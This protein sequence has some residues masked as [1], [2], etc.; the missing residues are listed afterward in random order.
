M[1]SSDP[2]SNLLGT[3]YKGKV[4]DCYTIG[5][6]RVLIASDRLSA[7]DRV[8]PETIPYKGQVLNQLATFFLKQAE[9]IVQ[10]HLMAVPDPNV[11]IAKEVKAV[12]LEIV[13]RGYLTG[14]AWRDYQAGIFNNQYGLNL[15][16]GLTMN[17]RLENSIITPTT[18]VND[19]HDAPITLAQA[20]KIVSDLGGD[21]HKLTAIAHKLFAQGQSIAQ[22]A[23]LIL[24]D[25]KYEFGLN[26]YGE[27]ILIDEIHTPDS[28]RYWHEPYTPDNPQ[29]LSKEYFRE[30]L[31]D[32]GFKGD[33]ELPVLPADL[34]DELSNRYIDLYQQLT[35]LEFVPAEG[36]LGDRLMATLPNHPLIESE[37]TENELED[38]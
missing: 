21:F 35:G 5:N 11:M 38:A 31:L 10:T 27:W 20:E 18:K 1:I 3:V 26:Q 23:G 34:I 14:S 22:A 36:K 2:L 17:S 29:Q 13:V 30:W 24:V 25:T 12:P 16:D 19:G 33:G 32:R 15:P 7:F 9:K 37:L 4:R 28:S 8:F 6:Y